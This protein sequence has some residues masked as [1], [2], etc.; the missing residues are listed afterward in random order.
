MDLL[1][2]LKTL[3]VTLWP[4]RKLQ[5]DYSAV[6]GFW[7]ERKVWG[8]FL[9]LAF[10]LSTNS[11]RCVYKWPKQKCLIVYTTCLKRTLVLDNKL[12]KDGFRLKCILTLRLGSHMCELDVDFTHIQFAW[13]ASG[14]GSQWSRI[15]QVGGGRRADC[16][17]AQCVFG[18]SSGANSGKNPDLNR[19]WTSEDVHRTPGTI[20]KPLI[21][22]PG[23]RQKA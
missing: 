9:T 10:F 8:Y 6:D 5:N 22:E 12:E 1:L 4:A 15:T 11:F 14:T 17:R 23:L 20:P 3:Q 2:F 7:S 18:S 19:T 16:K 13:H 21:C